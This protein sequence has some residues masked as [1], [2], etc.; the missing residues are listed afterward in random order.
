MTK[1]MHVIASVR[2]S[3]SVL[4]QLRCQQGQLLLLNACNSA[5]S[6]GLY[7]ALHLSICL[8]CSTTSLSRD[9]CWSS[10]CVCVDSWIVLS[11][12]R[13][14]WT[15]SQIHLSRRKSTS[16]CHC[17]LCEFIILAIFNTFLDPGILGIRDIG[18]AKQ[19]A[20][21]NTTTDSPSG[22]LPLQ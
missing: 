5:L 9:Y 16:S 1:W 22:T 18:I 17:R 7:T 8:I 12:V 21:L 4:L 14:R 19:F 11:P 2:S 10:V 15:M 20:I 3:F 6:T 13:M